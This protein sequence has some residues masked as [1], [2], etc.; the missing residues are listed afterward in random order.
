MPLQYASPQMDE[1]C[2]FVEEHKDSVE[3]H[4]LLEGKKD[5]QFADN[6]E[7]A[8]QVLALNGHNPD[9]LGLAGA[10]AGDD[11]GASDAED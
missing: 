10:R 6:Y 8:R 11:V 5:A 1:L 2:R 7:Y 9:E 3:F 4:E